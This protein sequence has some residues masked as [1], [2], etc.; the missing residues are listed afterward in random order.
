VLDQDG[1]T[2]TLL[3]YYEQNPWGPRMGF[4]IENNR[5]EAIRFCISN[6]VIN[7]ASSTARFITNPFGFEP[8]AYSSQSFCLE[9][10]ILS[11]VNYSH[12]TTVEYRIEIISVETGATLVSSDRIKLIPEPTSLS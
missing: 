6:I 11:E 3:G 1:V 4:I 2:I 12:V 5:D 7:G 10:S 9:S 8:G